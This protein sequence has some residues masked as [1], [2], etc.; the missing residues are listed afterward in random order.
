M[1]KVSLAPPWAANPHANWVFTLNNY[2]QSDIDGLAAAAPSFKHLAYGKEVG[3]SGTPHLQGVLCTIGRGGTR[4]SAL[5][6]SLDFN[7]G[8]HFEPM[9]GSYVQALTYCEKDCTPDNPI[10]QFGE[11]P[12][13]K[14]KN[15]ADRWSHAM[16]LAKT[17]DIEAIPADLY[18]KFSSFYE[19]MAQ[20]HAPVADLD[21]VCGIWLVGPSGSGKSRWVREKYPN[22]SFYDKRCNKWFDGY[23]G[24]RHKAVV[25]DDMDTSHAFMAYDINRWADR[26]AFNAEVKGSSIRIRPLNVIVTSRYT[27][28]EIFASTDTSTRESIIRRFKVQRIGPPLLFAIFSAASKALAPKPAVTTD[29][30]EICTDCMQS[31]CICPI[32]LN[33]V[34][35]NNE[36]TI[37]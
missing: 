12:A 7:P 13:S 3:E 29:D 20:R 32:A 5:K 37:N 14:G 24:R 18:T 30:I 36:I 2:K 9:R 10:T 34:H 4:L 21:D 33:D 28:E 8:F 11:A 26:Y 35:D 31:E 16:D 15:L 1:P 22:E 23:D 6:K 17:G 27:I 19:R 25:I